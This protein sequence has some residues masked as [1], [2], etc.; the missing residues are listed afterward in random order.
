MLVARRLPHGMSNAF[1]RNHGNNPDGTPT[2]ADAEE[3]SHLVV[4][5]VVAVVVAVPLLDHAS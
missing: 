2:P 3:P 5:V 4:V 1:A